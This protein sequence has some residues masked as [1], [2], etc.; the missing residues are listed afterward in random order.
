M[1]EVLLGEFFNTDFIYIKFK[2]T[3]VSCI[4]QMWITTKQHKLM[5]GYQLSDICSG[6]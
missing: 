4:K 3:L 1:L 6:M 2:L 5:I